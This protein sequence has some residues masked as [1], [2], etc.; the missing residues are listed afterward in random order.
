MTSLLEYFHETAIK[1]G[2]ATIIQN[3]FK[4]PL[5]TSQTLEMT[6]MIYRRLENMPVVTTD[7]DVDMEAELFY[8]LLYTVM[9]NIVLEA[10][11]KALQEQLR[12]I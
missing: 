4:L 6:D 10:K 2:I 9:R 8:H 1:N 7:D 12:D 5:T 11:V 3:D